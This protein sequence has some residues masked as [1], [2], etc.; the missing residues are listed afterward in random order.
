MIWPSLWYPLPV[1]TINED[2][3]WKITK[4]LYKMLLLAGGTNQH[5]PS[6]FRHAPL[7][8]FGLDL[9][10]ISDSQGIAQIQKF[11][12]HAAIPTPTGMLMN[13]SLELA[14]VEVGTSWSIF[15]MEFNDYGFLLTD[16]WIKSLWA[17][18]STY[19]IQLHNPEQV[20]PKIQREGDSFIM[21]CIIST[22][23]F[24]TMEWIWIN[25]CRMALRAMTMADII[26]GDGKWI[27]PEAYYFHV[28]ECLASSYGWP[29]ECPAHA[30]IRLWQKVLRS[31]S[32]DSLHLSFFD[33]LG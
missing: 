20:L 27:L 22:G 21:E 1:T 16:C 24:M 8:F 6:T 29:K 31:I 30:D 4:D 28:D 5:F 7:D 12:T 3:S 14:Q 11:L 26:T 9:P 2:D 25:H 17:F 33:C 15:D 23:R 13:A 19:S 32:S 10:R 18:S